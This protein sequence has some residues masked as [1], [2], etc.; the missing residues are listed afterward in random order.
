MLSTVFHADKTP[1]TLTIITAFNIGM[2]MLTTLLCSDIRMIQE[3][4][5]IFW[6]VMSRVEGGSRALQP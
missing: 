2:R 4:T 5:S 1:C 3:E 6:E